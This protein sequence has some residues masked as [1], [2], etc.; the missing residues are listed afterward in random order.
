MIIYLKN[1][2]TL[3]IDDFYFN[4]WEIN[5]SNLFNSKRIHSQEN[6]EKLENRK[7]Y[8]TI[9]SDKITNIEFDCD[10]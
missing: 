3:T 5:I 8:L 10:N 7:K 6:K 2:H 4:L 1:K 9:I